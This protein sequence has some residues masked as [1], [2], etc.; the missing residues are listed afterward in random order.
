MENTILFCGFV[1][2]VL[3]YWLSINLCLRYKRKVMS[4]EKTLQPVKAVQDEAGH[5]YVIPVNLQEDF[6]KLHELASDYSN[7]PV[8][9]QAEIEFHDK[10]SQYRTGGDLNNVQLYA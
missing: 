9:E 5:W 3:V 7:E 8:Q 10:F 2:V 1:L 4:T 6:R